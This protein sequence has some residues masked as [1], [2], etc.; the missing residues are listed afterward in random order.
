M[1]VD[2]HEERQE[3]LVANDDVGISIMAGEEADA[4][5]DIL[6][7]ELGDRLRVSDHVTYIKLE[8]DAG[9]LEIRFADVA[10]ALGRRFTLSD[11][12]VVFSSYYGRPQVSDD[13]VAVYA[14][15]TA[16]VLGDGDDAG[17]TKAAVAPASQG[18]LHG[19]R[20]ARE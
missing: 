1:M 16:G 19:P 20:K 13:E 7:D 14:S 11:F 12:Q 17:A 10:E 18:S 6:R 9:K 8:T 15:M 4:I 3:G 2:R 5:V